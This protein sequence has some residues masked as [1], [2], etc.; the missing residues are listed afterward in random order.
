MIQ[1]EAANTLAICWKC[2]DFSAEGDLRCRRISK[3][4]TVGLTIGARFCP[5][6]KHGDVPRVTPQRRR[7]GPRWLLSGLRRRIAFWVGWP[8]GWWRCSSRKR[9]ARL[10]ICEGC[11]WNRSGKCDL[12]G[13]PV[14]LK[15]AMKSESCPAHLWP[16]DRA[17]GKN[18]RPCCGKKTAE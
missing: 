9:A 18:R 13:C 4:I 15:A 8:L 3:P 14:K 10:R 16:G 11:A 1:T 2:E 17:G 7:R 6:G 5:I 12:C